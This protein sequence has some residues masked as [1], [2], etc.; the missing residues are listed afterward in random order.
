MSF[1]QEHLLS[2]LILGGYLLLLWSLFFLAAF[3]KFKP[4]PQQP[5]SLFLFMA[6]CSV[7]GLV[8]GYGLVLVFWT[9]YSI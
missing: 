1:F 9:C 2:I 7:P 5:P 4:S 3:R 8:L 6:V